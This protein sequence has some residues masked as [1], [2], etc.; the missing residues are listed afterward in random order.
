MEI[1]RDSRGA[2]PFHFIAKPPSRLS[3]ENMGEYSAR[4]IK[5]VEVVDRSRKEEVVVGPVD[6]SELKKRIKDIEE[7]INLL[8][9]QQNT[10]KEDN[11]ANNENLQLRVNEIE[12]RQDGFQAQ[13]DPIEQR[14]EYQ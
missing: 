5:K 14:L 9:N 6:V 3:A 8:Q 12:D 4:D 1:G 13:I 2:T 10:Q 11:L 7:Q